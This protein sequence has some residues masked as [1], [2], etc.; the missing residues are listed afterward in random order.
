MVPDAPANLTAV[1]RIVVHLKDSHGKEYVAVSDDMDDQAA[2]AERTRI[3]NEHASAGA[4]NRWIRVGDESVQS[5]HI[6]R[7]RLDDTS[8]RE[9]EQWG[10]PDISRDMDF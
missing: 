5:K 6:A 4:E 9:P 10:G 7:I 1:K 3:E 2:E 8:P